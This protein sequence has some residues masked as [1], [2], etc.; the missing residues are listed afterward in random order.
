MRER[1][2]PL[3]LK[4][5]ISTIMYFTMKFEQLLWYFVNSPSRE[6]PLKRSNSV[7]F[8]KYFT[9]LLNFETLKQMPV[10]VHMKIIN[11]CFIQL[12]THN[13]I[14]YNNFPFLIM[15]KETDFCNIGQEPNSGVTDFTYL[16]VHLTQLDK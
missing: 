7:M 1:S 8:S 6:R 13:R 4:G 3:C 11:Y 9:Q 12:I 10:N 2:R 15:G 16:C 5:Y 14:L